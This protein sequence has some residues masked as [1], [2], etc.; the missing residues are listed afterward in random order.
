M[1]SL[2]CL[3]LSLFFFIEN[4]YAILKIPAD[5]IKNPRN[6]KLWTMPLTTDTLVGKSTVDT[7]T[8]KIYQLLNTPEQVDAASGGLNITLLTPTSSSYKLT[9]GTTISIDGIPAPSTGSILNLINKTGLS[10]TINN[11]TG[12]TAANRI[13]TGS[14]SNVLMANNSMLNFY[15]SPSVSRWFILGGASLA[16]VL[17]VPNGGTGLS[18]SAL[19]DLLVGNS[20]NSYEILSKGLS[21]YVLTAGASTISWQAAAGAGTSRMYF[22]ATY[23]AIAGCL[24]Q[25]GSAVD[26]AWV[27]LTDSDCSSTTETVDSTATCSILSATNGFGATCTG[28]DAG[29]YEMCFDFGVNEDMATSVTNFRIAGCS[30][31][32][33]C[34]VTGE[35]YSSPTSKIRNSVI[36]TMS[37]GYCGMGTMASSGT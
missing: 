16:G 7:F 25:L 34:A 35:T 18:A 6:T 21:G 10:L 24:P 20:T 4:A 37:W 12:A 22:E 28:M 32:S 2:L 1:K 31:S 30:G 19:G 14:G 23:N 29:T 3:F 9:N 15:Y 17:S 13:I 36:E 33:V 26:G 11:E 8:N 27:N 5:A